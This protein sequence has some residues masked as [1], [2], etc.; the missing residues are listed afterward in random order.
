MPGGDGT[1]PWGLGPR[2]GRAAGLCAGYRMP[3]FANRFVWP[4]FGGKWFGR[5]R[6]RRFGRP[7][8]RW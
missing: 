3:G 7:Y 1:G 8:R 6:W 4:P 5:F 2:T